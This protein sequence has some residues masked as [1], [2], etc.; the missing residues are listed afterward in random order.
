M[1]FGKPTLDIAFRTACIV[2]LLMTASHIRGIEASF[3]DTT[4]VDIE[5]GGDKQQ[6]IYLSLEKAVELALKNNRS[7]QTSRRQLSIAASQ[8]RSA[9]AGYYPQVTGALIAAQSVFNQVEGSPS[10]Q[11]L[12]TGAFDIGLDFP[13]DLS[14]SI[15]RSVQQA[16][17]TLINSKA[18]YV[19]GSQ[20]VIV[21]VYNQY[22][23]ILNARET[24][25]I[26]KAQVDVALQQLEI[27]KARLKTGRVAEV[28]VMT[29]RVQLNN[30]RQNL[31]VD[32][33]NYQ[34]ALANLRN[35]LVLPQD[36]E[37]VA[38]DQL[39]FS[40]VSFNYSD[41]VKNALR[42][43]LELKIARLNLESAR[44]SLKS[45]YDRYR[46]TLNVSANY[47]YAVSGNSV[48]EA[49]DDRPDE[50]SWAV[51]TSLRVPIFIFDGGQIR[52]SKIQALTNIGQ[53]E[54]NVLQ[55]REAIELEVR[56]ELTNLQNAQERVKLVQDTIE[57]AKES[58]RITERRYRMGVTSYLELVDARTNL[59][60][61]Q[62]N[63]L[64]A[65][66]SY[67]NSLI[68]LYRAL[69]RPLVNVDEGMQKGIKSIENAMH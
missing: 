37:I 7:L 44:I 42:N 45:T 20:D 66:I 49:I 53:A 67:S 38:T 15:G 61:A 47:G 24:I 52:E 1:R 5:T 57:L 48:G 30:N 6:P 63:L 60:N 58:Q 68:R 21:S 59:R 12:Y 65:L 11:E 54:A 22:N 25:A 36:A 62:L 46:P 27:A 31:K 50:P 35:T 51:T 19:L 32:E 4:S 40:P 69:G 43:R 29:A 18:Q 33:G 39:T 9:K 10:V 41:A 17:I 3:A 64:N 23:N 34:I 8:Y 26:D 16:L 14:G 28:D 55:T 2:I 56:N 13:L